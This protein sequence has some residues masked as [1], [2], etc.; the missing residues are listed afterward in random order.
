[1][2]LRRQS[3]KPYLILATLIALIFLLP[4][5]FTGA[6]RSGLFFV[7]SPFW[8]LLH[9]ITDP[10]SD[11]EK[12]IAFE[13]L[14]LENA[15]LRDDPF[16]RLRISRAPVES[17]FAK[18][19][20]RAPATWNREFWIDVGSKDP[21]VEKGCPVV[22]GASLVGIIDIVEST[23]SRVK[24]LSDSTLVPSVRAARGGKL[25]EE[26]L[27]HIDQV[28]EGL[29]ARSQKLHDP[30]LIDTLNRIRDNLKP[31][32][33]S[34]LLAKGEVNGSGTP[35]WRGYRNQ[36]RGIGFNYWFAD[37]A[38]PARDLKSGAVIPSSGKG[39][40]MPILQV[41]DLLVTTGMDGIFPAGL[42]VAKVE[43]IEPLR[44]GSATFELEAIPTAG[45]LIGLTH[46]YIL[47]IQ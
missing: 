46:V 22:I 6:L 29:T 38:G 23:R 31:N 15:L 16:S 19:I 33:Q 45:N 34:F 37:E 32:A 17:T 13:K 27:F 10:F 24:L 35:L 2:F 47:P 20:Y 30:S 25:D 21:L 41:G 18:V 14:E 1:M 7:T 28:V 3:K 36:V 5:S 40:Q 39:E 44:E 11:D 9:H 4:S 8:T 42:H 43:K 12:R 26:L